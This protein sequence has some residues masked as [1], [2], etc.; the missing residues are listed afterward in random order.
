MDRKQAALILFLICSC[1]AVSRVASNVASDNQIAE[2]V[3]E[4]EQHGIIIQQAQGLL[5]G[6]YYENMGQIGHQGVLYFGHILGGMIGFGGSSIFIRLGNTEQI[7]EFSFVGSDDVMP[8]ATDAVSHRTNFFLGDRGTY[9]DVAGFR[10]IVYED[11]WPG[12]TLSFETSAA[13]LRFKFCIEPKANP[14]DICLGYTDQGSTIIREKLLGARA[15]QDGKDVG[16]EYSQYGTN[17]LGFDLGQYDRLQLVVINSLLHSSYLGGSSADQA[18]FIAFD[19]LSNVYVAGTTHSLDFPTESGLN[20]RGGSADC[21]AL[22]FDSSDNSLLFASFIG[23]SADDFAKAA[24]IDSDG[25][26]YVTGNTQSADFPTQQAYDSTYN[27][28]TSDCFIFKLDSTGSSLVYSTFIGG[29]DTDGAE[30]IALGPRG[31]VYLTGYTWS[32]DFPTVEAFDYTHNGGGTDCFVLKINA[33]GSQLI[34]STYFGGSRSDRGQCIAVDAMGDAYVAGNTFSPDF[35]VERAYDYTHNG[36]Q[37]CFVLKITFTG[38]ALRFS[39]FIGGGWIDY[40]SAIAFDIVG[41]V[42]LTGWT[43]SLDFPTTQGYQT[44]HNGRAEAFIVKLNPAGNAI[45]Y[46]TLVGGSDDDFSKA[47]MIDS[48]NSVYITGTTDSNDFPTVNAQDDSYGGNS[49][50]FVLKFNEFGDSLLYATYLGGSDADHGETMSVDSLGNAVVAGWTASS[51]FNTGEGDDPSFNGGWSDCF[52]VILADAGDTDSDE[53]S[54]YEENQLGTNRFNEDTDSDGLSDGSEV[55]LY[56][57]DPKNADSDGDGL[58]D[59]DEVNIYATDP[60]DIDSDGDGLTDHDEI[61]IHNTNPNDTDSDGDGLNDGDEIVIYDTNPC[62]DDTDHDGLNDWD[63]TIIHLTNPRSSDT[64]QDGM[65]D[66]WEVRFS[67]DPLLNDSA[68]DEDLD[69]LLNLEEFQIGSHPDTNDTDAD[70]LSDLAEVLT[71]GTNPSS[72][73]TDNDALTDFDEIF[74]HSTNPINVDS[75]SDGMLDGWEVQYG[76]NPLLNDALGD[77]D[78]DGL[79]NVQEYQEGASPLTNDTDGDMLTDLDEVTIHGTNSGSADTDNDGLNDYEEVMLHAT[80][81]LD[82]DSDNDGLLDGLEINIYGTDALDDDTDDDLLPDGWEITYSLNPL[83]NDSHLDQD[84]DGVSNLQEYQYGINP[85]DNDTD[86]DSVSDYDELYLF[87]TEPGNSDSDNDGM[88]DGWELVYSLN[89]KLADDAERDLDSDGLSNL[90]EYEFFSR[91]NETDSDKDA[92][93]DFEEVMLHGTL[94]NSA[95]S[96]NDGMPDAWEIQ[97]LLDP[98]L[99]DSAADLDSDGLSNIEEYEN[100]AD[101]R[102]TDSD[103]DGLDD[104][105]EVSIHHTCPD[106]PDSDLDDLSDTLEVD[107]YG[108]DP[109]ES[110]TDFDGMPDGWEVQFGLQPLSN[111]ASGDPDSD[112]LTNLMEYQYH[113]YPNRTDTDGDGLTDAGEVN[114]YGTNPRW[115]DSDWDGLTDYEELFSTKTDP[116]NNDTDSDGATDGDEVNFCRTNPNDADSDDDGMPDGWE[117]LNDLNPLIN[118]RDDDHDS[119]GFTN[120]E[121]FLLGISANNRDTDGDELSDYDEMHTYGTLPNRADSDLDGMIDGWEVQYGLNPLMN[122]SANDPDT[123]DLSNLQEYL[124]GANPHDSDSDEDGLNDFDEVYVHG[125]H[126]SLADTDQD[127]LDDFEEVTHLSTQ[128]NN[129]DSDD[130]CMPDGWEVGNSLNPLVN[131][132]DY[133]YDSDGLTNLNEYFYLTDPHNSDSDGDCLSDYEEVY[134]F[135]TDPT[136]SDSDGDLLTDWEEIVLYG[137]DPNDNDSDSDGI[138]DGTEIEIGTDPVTVDSDGDG[139]PDGWEYFSGF[140]PTNSAVPIIEVLLFNS[141]WIFGVMGSVL[142]VSLFVYVRKQRMRT[143]SSHQAPR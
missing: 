26:I 97:Y 60:N 136:L 124:N 133:D 114:T 126:P 77:L 88:P 15:F 37:D 102:E 83:E 46:S 32:S 132:A 108:T 85:S 105:E 68:Q 52:I 112:G 70:G 39:T 110:D 75:D 87:F 31:E 116:N 57:T 82:S 14:S 22:K 51:D 99:D 130:D 5:S 78:S 91:P 95:D 142:I 74:V 6:Q 20:E 79:T 140:D 53:L 29:S 127:G 12:I 2:M 115:S 56:E 81:P 109:T 10:Q 30:S 11:L 106:V 21:F 35:H 19:T 137:T 9:V 36:H 121:E 48:V 64:D 61:V 4:S 134:R 128:P 98:L 89:P 33:E 17:M 49:D 62:T 59:G 135:G 93:S 13:A 43:Y 123:D 100:G 72:S 28:G 41:H 118:D 143:L 119:D 129:S 107:V 34:F 90:L 138:D 111:D 131:D 141:V 23:G 54:D 45:V 73:D 101:P 7:L 120:W 47:I 139:I 103:G 71:Y 50:C 65:P 76:L 122:D 25:N 104:F 58:N 84:F 24:T 3:S 42:Y 86:S 67:L 38:R 8:K 66:A 40:A 125:T 69:G 80:D 16:V 18:Q 96:D 27:G 1:L 55:L 94:P 117:V 113:V 92:L 44:V 63:E